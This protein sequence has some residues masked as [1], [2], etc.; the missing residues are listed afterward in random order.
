MNNTAELLPGTLD[1]LILKARNVAAYAPGDFPNPQMEL[2][3]I[4]PEKS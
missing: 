2:V 4:L 1:M 3:I